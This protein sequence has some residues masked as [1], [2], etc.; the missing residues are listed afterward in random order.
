M[1]TNPPNNPI[2]ATTTTKNLYKLQDLGLSWFII[3]PFSTVSKKE[4]KTQPKLPNFP[5]VVLI[6]KYP[7]LKDSYHLHWI[8]NLLEGRRLCLTTNRYPHVY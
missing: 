5:F 3:I 4:K 7:F 1:K 2:Q 6:N 8:V